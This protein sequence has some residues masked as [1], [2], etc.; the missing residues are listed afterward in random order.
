M[1]VVRIRAGL[2]NQ[3]FQYALGR[4]LAIENDTELKLD[5]TWYKR[6]H[7][8]DMTERAFNLP[9]FDIEGDIVTTEELRK[10]FNIRGIPVPRILVHTLNRVSEK[11]NPLP[12]E[13]FPRL[14]AHCLNY[15]W[16]I[17]CEYPPPE[18]PKWPYGRRYFPGM[19]EKVGDLYLAGFW[20]S[21]KYFEDIADTLRDDFSVVAPLTGEDKAVADRIEDAQAVGVHVRRGDK[22]GLLPI[23]Y[24][25][26]A[27]ETLRQSVENPTFFVFSNDPAWTQANLDLG[28]RTTYVTHN[29]GSTDYQDLRL[30][31]LCD[32]QIIASSSFSWWPAWLNENPDKRVYY[33]KGRMTWGPEDDFIPPE[34][35]PVDCR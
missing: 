5:D 6:S 2:G 15:Y 18:N 32:H 24:Y 16:E 26:N 35:H 1:I 8:S 19:L 27:A 22:S 21:R 20:E 17:R 23:R 13:L 9:K 4:R 29:D 10:F 7:Y 34:W 31:R 30:L 12:R 33:P 3:M 11:E 14:S 25:E 28:P